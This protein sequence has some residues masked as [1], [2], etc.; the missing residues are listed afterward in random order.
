[1]T[2]IGNAVRWEEELTGFPGSPMIVARAV[3][4]HPISL[5]PEALTSGWINT[6]DYS[7]IFSVQ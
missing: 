3:V 2:C 4:V 5:L 6:H 7:Q 1:M